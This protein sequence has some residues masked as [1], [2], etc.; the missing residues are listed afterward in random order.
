VPKDATTKQEKDRSAAAV[1]VEELRSKIN[2]HNYR[3]HVL[4]APEISDAEYD[5][6]MRELQE[7]EERFPELITPDSPT[8]R[9]G[10]PPSE[11]FAPVQHSAPLLSLDNAFS[12]ADLDAWYAR[13]VRGL[14]HDPRFVCEPKI[15]GLSVV[16][17]YEDGRFVRGAT[18]GDGYV[19]ED[20]T[21][22][23]RTIRA[24]PTSLRAKAPPSWLEIR[25]EVFLRL[26]DFEQINKDQGEQGCSAR[27]IRR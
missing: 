5:A 2:H 23:I 10:A 1:E 8:Q 4:D 15:D 14:E 24:V 17:V 12:D 25:G 11:L 6:L 13:V 27:R 20:V 22:N 18:R 21:A 7:L 3:Y 9:V 16:L 26:E 19:G